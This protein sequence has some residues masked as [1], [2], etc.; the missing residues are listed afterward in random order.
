[1]DD[2]ILTAIRRER[3]ACVR[4]VGNTA[5]MYTDDQEIKAVLFTL[6]QEMILRTDPDGD[7]ISGW[8]DSNMD[9]DAAQDLIL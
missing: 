6:Y 3:E 4:I 5:K 8:I 1:M 7:N 9:E 2:K